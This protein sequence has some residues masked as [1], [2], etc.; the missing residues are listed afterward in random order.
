MQPARLQRVAL[1]LAKH[2]VLLPLVF[3]PPFVWAI[4]EG[5]WSFALALLIPALAGSVLWAT[6]I[7]LPLPKDLRQVEAV[8]VLAL[9]FVVTPLMSV[10]AFTVLGM[11]PLDALFEA[12]S[13]LTTTGLSMAGSTN[14]WPFAAFFLRSWMQWCGGLAMATAVLA[15]LIGPGATARK[16]GKVSL[17]EGDRIASTR[18]RARQ[19][20]GAYAGLT[21]VFGLAISASV[22][23]VP[24][25]MLLTFSAVS[26]GG[27]AYRADSVAGY[28]G[29]TQTL[30]ILASLA[31]AVS[32]LAIALAF[33]GAVRDAWN[34][35]SLQ[36]LGLWCVGA[37]TVL[38]VLM[39]S[40]G[41]DSYAVLMWNLL[42]A[43]STAGFSVGDMPVAPALLVF[44]IVV[45]MVGGDLGSTAG[46][47]KLARLS[48]L[49]RA[50]KHA[51]RAPRLPDNAIA[52]L[53]EHGQVVK[54]RQLIALMAFLLFYVTSVMVLWVA[55]LAYGYAPLPALFDI[56]SAFS[57]VGLSTGVIAPDIPAPLK[58]A[59]VLAML[60]GRLEFV[61]VILL[62]LPNTWVTPPQRR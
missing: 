34:I 10:P 15:M 12:M 18:S 33:R 7:R 61:A 5:A 4:A 29:L 30:V 9:L 26:T 27:F 62:I 54:D 59:T 56:V 49:M 37:V 57:T 31:G 38:V 42:S 58:A 19:L 60:L 25:G 13:A 1:A 8:V 21:V 43:I 2:G 14:D 40:L 41:Q 35:G 11:S 6:V 20:L 53:R 36:R 51:T 45:M 24:E 47:V 17:D 39:Y 16:L 44:F 55:F 48:T 50:A 46:G 32:L 22:G 28:S 3:V 52:P 23:S